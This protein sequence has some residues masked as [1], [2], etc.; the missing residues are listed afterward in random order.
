MQKVVSR[1]VAL[2]LGGAFV[3]AFALG[4][5][6]LL[7]I[8]ILA[9]L[10]AFLWASLAIPVELTALV[11]FTA[12]LLTGLAPD[13]VALAGFESKA[14]WLVFAGLVLSEAIS[15]HDMGHALFDR[16]LRRLTSYPQLIWLVASTGLFMAFFIPSAMG[17]VLLLAPLVVALADRLGL[18]A[19]DPRRH[20]LFLATVLGAVVPAFTIITSNVPNLVLM[21]AAEAI[22]DRTLTYGEYLA[23]NFPVLGLGTF[24]LIPSLVLALFPGERRL[25]LQA[26]QPTPWTRDQIRIFCVLAVLLAFWTTDKLHG[27]SSAWIG[28]AAAVF[29][30]MPGVGLLPA[31]TIGKI[32]FGPWFFVAGSIGLGGVV[33]HSGLGDLL[34]G[35]VAALVPLEGL[36]N[37]LKFAVIQLTATIL[38]VV[39]TLPAIPA[40]FTPLVGSIADSLNWPLDAALLAQ[41]PAFV[42]FAFPFQAP[43]VMV[44][45]TVLGVPL[46]AAMRL[47]LRYFV[48]AALVLSP[49]HYLWGRLLG[50]FP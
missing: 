29:M 34:W 49:L 45:L 46:R 2:G 42:I 12:L 28:L 26:V 19:D 8:A 44:G 39:A 36:P 50:V 31:Q 47:M 5:S 15:R 32:N 41:V 14:I 9:V 43:P 25:T 35:Q 22:Y 6:P 21:G 40:V 1:T 23:L 17:R 30:L 37:P 27:I 38:A 18:A 33:S 48:V 3:V 13:H 20:G 16:L 24:V 4:A 7:C 10:T 11:F